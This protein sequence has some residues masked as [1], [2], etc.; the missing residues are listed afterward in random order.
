MSKKFGKTELT[1]LED[2]VRNIKGGNPKDCH[3]S[4]VDFESLFG[5]DNEGATLLHKTFDSD[6]NGTIEW[7]ELLGG[8]AILSTGS[9][10]EKAE[11]MF[12]TWDADG[13]GS[14]DE[15]EVYQMMHSS[16]TIAAAAIV[17][18]MMGPMGDLMSTLSEKQASELRTEISESIQTN[19]NQE[20][21]EE[22]VKLLFKE[23]D[24]DNDGKI[25]L[26][27]FKLHCQSNDNAISPFVEALTN[28]VKPITNKEEENCEQM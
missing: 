20:D 7:N 11:M 4:I 23:A 17:N 27:E 26:E 16:I 24:I 21:V 9:T 14:L 19:I 12:N 2:K 5:I 8:L 13:N 25:T 10:E 28:V 15:K 6:K 22:A 1:L 3:L 18:S